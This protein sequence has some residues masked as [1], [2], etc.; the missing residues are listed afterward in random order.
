MDSIDQAKLK[1]GH[2]L[3]RLALVQSQRNRTVAK[4]LA[5]AI[6]NRYGEFHL[7]N[8]GIW[9]FP[10]FCLQGIWIV[11]SKYPRAPGCLD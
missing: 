1:S 9:I 3:H 6:P 8:M 11:Q 4:V 10:Y 7:V 2:L 5:T